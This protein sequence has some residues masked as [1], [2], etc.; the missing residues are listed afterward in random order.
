MIST[1][2]HSMPL[3]TAFIGNPVSSTHYASATRTRRPFTA[4]ALFLGT[5]KGVPSEPLTPFHVLSFLPPSYFLSF[6]HTK[7]CPLL[8]IVTDGQGQNWQ[9]RLV[10]SAPEVM[11]A[12]EGNWAWSYLF[13]EFLFSKAVCISK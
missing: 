13:L 2:H 12:S 7:A 1:F 4:A 11:D 8:P 3:A 10:P 6:S 9:R 5:D